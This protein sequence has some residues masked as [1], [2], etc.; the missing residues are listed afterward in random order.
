[1]I[2]FFEHKVLEAIL[3]DLLIQN[4]VKKW[5]FDYLFARVEK[6][7]SLL[8]NLG[9]LSVFKAIILSFWKADRIACSDCAFPV[10][11]NIQ[12]AFVFCKIQS[13]LS[14]FHN[15]ERIAAFELSARPNQVLQAAFIV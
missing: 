14:L 11:P 13:L 10:S 2:N 8:F 4:L 7:Y 6:F 15:A 9:K 12:R 5:L 3:G 1:M